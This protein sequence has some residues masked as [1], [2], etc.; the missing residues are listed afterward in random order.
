M[1]RLS[2]VLSR[3]RIPSVDAPSTIL[4][5]MLLYVWACAD[6]TARIQSAVS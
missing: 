5:S 6:S 3:S 4:T 1:R 2:R